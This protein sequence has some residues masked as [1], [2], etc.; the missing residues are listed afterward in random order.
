MLLEEMDEVEMDDVGF[1]LNSESTQVQQDRILRDY[2]RFLTLIKIL[3]VG[4]AYA[5]AEKEEIKFPTEHKKLY[6][7][8]RKRVSPSSKIAHS[9]DISRF[10]IFVAR[11]AKGRSKSTMPTYLIV[12]LSSTEL[13]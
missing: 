13:R 6:V 9:S 4:Y 8:I 7:Q 12:V 10:V 11:Y 1:R 3:K 5:D 2:E